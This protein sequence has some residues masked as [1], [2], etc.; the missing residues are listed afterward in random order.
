METSYWKTLKIQGNLGE[1]L[2]LTLGTCLNLVNSFWG[3]IKFREILKNLQKYI[4]RLT[5]VGAV[6]TKPEN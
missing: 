4:L 5:F 1:K 6:C 3:V 2:D